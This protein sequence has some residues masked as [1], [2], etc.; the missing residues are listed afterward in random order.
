LRFLLVPLL[1]L[2]KQLIEI[3][4]LLVSDFQLLHEL[5]F[6]N[7]GIIHL[8]GEG[9]FLNARVLI[10]TLPDG[11]SQLLPSDRVHLLQSFHILSVN[12]ALAST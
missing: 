10:F 5:L 8:P 9:V 2:F 7:G 1:D 11:R 4:I 3:L 6:M 12:T